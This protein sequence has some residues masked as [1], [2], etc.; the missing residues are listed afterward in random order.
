MAIP[1]TLDAPAGPSDEA[2]VAAFR[3]AGDKEAIDCLLARY[4]LPIR[5][6]VF[7]MVL[8]HTTA[9]DLTQEIFLRALRRLE[10]FR[11]ESSFSTWLCRV[12]MNTTYSYLRSQR[13][14]RVQYRS[15]LPD[16]VV[17]ADGAAQAVLYG[18]LD[19]QVATALA[20]LSPKL[21]AVIILTAID[22]R[23]IEEVAEIE[24]CSRAMV[25]WQLHKA[26]RVLKRRLQ[27]YLSI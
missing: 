21:R 25:Y 6:V 12:A 15:A 10:T 14:G 3:Q 24:N 7:A 16:T 8:D 23:S 22:R 19:E 26:R 20:T 13:A 2:L 1:I 17:R 18:E 9:D 4:L 5:A 27:G 11:G